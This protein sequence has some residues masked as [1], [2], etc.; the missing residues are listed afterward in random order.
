MTARH[1]LQPKDWKSGS[2]AERFASVRGHLDQVEIPC[3]GVGQRL[4]GLHDPDL[5]A[6]LRDQPNLGYPDPVVDP[7]LVPLGRPPV[8]P[9][10]NRH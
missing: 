2:H 10:G 6:I 7:C 9:T 4:G 8:E 1:P 3:L 5:I